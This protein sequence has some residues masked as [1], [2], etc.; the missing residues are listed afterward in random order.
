MSR[1]VWIG[2]GLAVVMSAGLQY[3]LVTIGAELDGRAEQLFEGF[4]LTLAAAILTWVVVWVQGR[5]VAAHAE[6]EM[7]P[8]RQLPASVGRSSW[9]R[10][11]P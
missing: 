5:R 6:Q 9:P 10:S 4:M 11:P 7:R 8:A 1:F 2:V 3:G